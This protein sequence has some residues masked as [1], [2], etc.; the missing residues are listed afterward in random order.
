MRASKLPPHPPLAA[1]K[2]SGVLLSKRFQHSSEPHVG[3]RITEISGDVT[4]SSMEPPKHAHTV[5]A[6]ARLKN[7]TGCLLSL[8]LTDTEGSRS[9]NPGESGTLLAKGPGD[10]GEHN[11]QHLTCVHSQ[12]G[13]HN[14]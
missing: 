11:Q 3:T 4:H 9:V 12:M 5:S 8:S 14:L 1:A 10:S 6:H 13:I 7:L 2:S